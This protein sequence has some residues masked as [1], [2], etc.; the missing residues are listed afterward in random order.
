MQKNPPKAYKNAGFLRGKDARP[1]RI[2]SEFLEPLSRFKYFDVKD[3]VVF[4]GSARIRSRQESTAK[5]RKIKAEMRKSKRP[6]RALLASMDAAER[7]V[8]MSS[9]YE[10]AVELARILTKW[11]RSLK[12]KGRF[13]VCSGGG[14]GIMEAANRGAMLAKGRS[15]GLGIS[16]PMEQYP[17]KYITA[18]LNLEFHYFF[19]RK[20]WFMYLGKAL[21]AFPGGFGTMDELMELLTLLQT[22]KIR[23]KMTVIL[24]GRSFWNTVVNLHALCDMGMISK[25]DF[26]LFSF[27]DTPKEAFELLKKGLTKNYL[28][29]DPDEL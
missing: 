18:E 6:S 9:Y 21:I 11:S 27:A 2:L 14:P 29:P 3:T 16:L 20:Y 8:E 26:D 28:D 25:D 22:G 10:D 19:M 23:K 15:L 7:A 1:V 13:V 24:Y 5:L 17:N 12:D 4:F